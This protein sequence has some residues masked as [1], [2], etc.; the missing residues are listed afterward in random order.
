MKNVTKKVLLALAAL[1]VLAV[2]SFIGVYST[3]IRTM[4][5]IER[6][7]D[8][9]DGYNLFRMDVKYDYSLD[10]V[11]NY[12]IKDNQSAFA[13]ILAE[14]LPFLPVRISVPEFGCSAF[15][16]KDGTGSV[17]MGRNYDF[18]NNTSAMMVYCAPKDGYKSV[19]FA[20]LDN[21][22]ANKLESVGKKLA[23][24]AAPFVCL[25]GM[26][27]K[28]VSIAVLTLDSA[29]TFQRTGK[30]VIPT[31]LAIRLVLDRAASTEEAIE[32]LESYDMFATS[33]RDYHFYIADASGDARVVEY[34]C[35]SDTRKLAATPR[36][37]ITNFYALYSDRVLPNQ[38]NGIY[39]HGRE[40]CDKI[41]AVLRANSGS[42]SVDI[43]WEALRAAAQLPKENDLTS[44]TQWSIGY[45]NKNLTAQAVI[46]RNWQDVICYDLASNRVTAK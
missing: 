8:Y 44:N 3:R 2:A 25:D 12:G 10:N 45:D 31:T 27:E 26:N 29:P 14:A 37:A 5:S 38:K 35:H 40:R 28:G 17:L 15:S 6:L 7:T 4:N 36:S 19:G 9:S 22:S 43:A 39:G 18:R 16:E 34:D 20:A 30:P 13:A 41:E 11:V 23:A 46:R 1:T 42:Y 21:L 32:L 24:L 33:G